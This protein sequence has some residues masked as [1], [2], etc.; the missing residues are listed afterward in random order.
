VIFIYQ[1]Y[2]IKMSKNNEKQVKMSK[3]RYVICENVKVF[4]I[5]ADKSQKAQ[6][7]L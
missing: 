3:N 5:F 2:K 6:R 1:K 7:H 4:P